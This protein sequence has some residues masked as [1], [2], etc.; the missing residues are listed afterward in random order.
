MKRRPCSA[1]VRCSDG[2]TSAWTVEVLIHACRSLGR[3]SVMGREPAP[4]RRTHGKAPLA[5]QRR[6]V[7]A[8]TPQAAATSGSVNI[9]RP[10]AH[11]GPELDHDGDCACGR[12]GSGASDLCNLSRF[13]SET[14]TR[15][16]SGCVAAE[17][18]QDVSREQQLG[19][20]QYLG[21]LRP[22]E[23]NGGRT[24]AQTLNND[25]WGHR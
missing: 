4:G 5:I 3:R 12:N 25:S 15:P 20:Y 16:F 7:F 1:T 22:R 13:G 9:A 6:T 10:L 18:G 8:L 24:E 2:V 11:V 17:C 14:T 23:A 21:R 19:L